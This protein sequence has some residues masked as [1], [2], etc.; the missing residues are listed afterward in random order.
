M[1]FVSILGI[2]TQIDKNSTELQTN[3][4]KLSKWRNLGAIASQIASF[5]TDC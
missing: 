4:C 5:S 1:I 3:M 2:I